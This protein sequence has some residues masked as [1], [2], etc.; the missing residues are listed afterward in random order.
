MTSQVTDMM[1]KVV[2]DYLKHRFE[3]RVSILRVSADI[4]LGKRSVLNNPTRRVVEK[5]IARSSLGW[6]YLI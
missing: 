2:F 4:S 6:L 5:S 3:G 1:Q